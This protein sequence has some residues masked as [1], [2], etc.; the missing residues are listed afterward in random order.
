[1]ERKPCGRPKCRLNRRVMCIHRD[2]SDYP[3]Y[4]D[5]YIKAQREDAANEERGRIVKRFESEFSPEKIVEDEEF[6]EYGFTPA[7][8]DV[9]GSLA[10]FY[11][12]LLKGED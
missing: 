1:M 4:V 3:A 10:N 7:G 12:D 11:L 2:C 8:V 5:K 6:W 9:W